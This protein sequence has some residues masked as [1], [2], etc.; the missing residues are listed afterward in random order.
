MK[1]DPSRLPRPA[2]RSPLRSWLPVAASMWALAHASSA[3]GQA[4]LVNLYNLEALS[5]PYEIALTSSVSCGS[6]RCDIS[7]SM[8]SLVLDREVHVVW[9]DVT[10]APLVSGSNAYLSNFYSPETWGGYVEATEVRKGN[11]GSSLTPNSIPMAVGTADFTGTAP[12][13]APCGLSYVCN[14]AEYYYFPP[15]AFPRAPA[16]AGGAGPGATTID[17]A[18]GFTVLGTFTAT[19]SSIFVDPEHPEDVGDRRIPFIEFA[20]TVAVDAGQ[21]LYRYSVSNTTDR[22][23]TFT[24]E[25]AGLQGSVDPFSTVQRELITAVAPGITPSLTQ[26]T[27]STDDPSPMSTDFASGLEM[28]AP[29]PEPTAWLQFGLGL[30]LLGALGRRRATIAASCARA[31][32]LAGAERGCVLGG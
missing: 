13:S 12:G 32:S 31:Q 2:M 1:S 6:V 15:G 24:W 26:W 5:P 27:L 9:K 28:Y 16:G 11:L 18:T 7:Y 17:A 22:P 25:Q 19:Q 23:I 14:D 30:A 20:S 21:Y 3:F 4:P 29:V 8:L 10:G